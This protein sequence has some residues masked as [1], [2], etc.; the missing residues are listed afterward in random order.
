NY[1]EMRGYDD[2]WDVNEAL[3]Y[4]NH[5][6][7]YGFWKESTDAYSHPIGSTTLSNS[8]LVAVNQDPVDYTYVFTN[9]VLRSGL[10]TSSQKDDI[11]GKWI[12]GHETIGRLK[13]LL[14]YKD[15]SEETKEARIKT[16]RE[17]RGGNWSIESAL[18]YINHNINVGF[19]TRETIA[20]TEDSN[21]KDDPILSPHLFIDD[22]L[23]DGAIDSD[24][25]DD[26]DGN[27]L[28][29]VFTAG[30][31]GGR[32]TISWVKDLLEKK[33]L[34]EREKEVKEDVQG[35]IEIMIEERVGVVPDT[36]MKENVRI[37]RF[38]KDNHECNYWYKNNE[39]SSFK[40]HFGA[41]CSNITKDKN[42]FEGIIAISQASD[43]IIIEDKE[44]VN[45][46]SLERA[47]EAIKILTVM[48][49]VDLEKNFVLHVKNSQILGSGEWCNYLYNGEKWV[50]SGTYNSVG[51]CKEIV[52]GYTYIP[53]IKQIISQYSALYINDLQ[54]SDV[55]EVIDY[56]AAQ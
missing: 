8:D 20:Y 38:L 1:K 27:V 41:S 11:D 47:I 22:L 18:D 26:I 35:A 16:Y 2:L 52:E 44:I 30:Y 32:E 40:V 54:Y 25:K 9:D 43:K 36:S 48:R 4:L 5:N 12:L 45:P 17:T 49:N 3:D 14:Q 23:K 39:W 24:E 31:Y 28:G 37:K 56:L 29:I 7:K 33:L 13:E 10:I 55:G 6:L 50:V 21:N 42:Y 53:G 15:S 34:A 46:D 51:K 19:W